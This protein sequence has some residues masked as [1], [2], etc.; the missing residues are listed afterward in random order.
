LDLVVKGIKYQLNEIM[1]DGVK[2]EKIAGKCYEMLLF[3]KEEIEIYLDK[4]VYIVKNENK[5]IYSNYIQ[6][7]SSIEYQFA[8][9]CETREDIEFYFKLPGWFTIETPIGKYNPDWH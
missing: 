3:D 1:I 7:D 8:Q 4:L 2:N 5:T 9:D 6:L